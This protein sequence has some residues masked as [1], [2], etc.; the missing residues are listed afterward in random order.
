MRASLCN[1]PF[2]NHSYLTDK[3]LIRKLT[4]SPFD[5]FQIYKY[6]Y[7]IDSIFIQQTLIKRKRCCVL[8]F[9]FCI[10][11][12]IYV[13]CHKVHSL[14]LTWPSATRANSPSFILGDQ[15]AVSWVRKRGGESFQEREGEPLGCY[16]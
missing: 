12:A 10:P 2:K 8:L 1:I 3:H 15:G 11:Q 4:S 6:I 14:I 9:L 13:H 7:H 16:S 5:R